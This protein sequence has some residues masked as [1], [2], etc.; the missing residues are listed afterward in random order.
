MTARTTPKIL[1]GAHSRPTWRTVQLHPLKFRVEQVHVDYGTRRPLW[2]AYRNRDLAEA[3]LFR[4]RRGATRY[5]LGRVA[6]AM[7]CVEELTC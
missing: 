3:H 6:T 1:R 7:Q 4:T 2:L 5:A